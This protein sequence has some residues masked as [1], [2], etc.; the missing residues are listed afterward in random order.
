M[1]ATVISSYARS[2]KLEKCWNVKRVTAAANDT[3]FFWNIYNRILARGVFTKT[4]FSKYRQRHCNFTIHP[5]QESTC[6]LDAP[7]VFCLEE[8]GC[9]SVSSV[10]TIQA[11]RLPWWQMRQTCVL[12]TAHPNT[13]QR[14]NG[15][16]G[17]KLC[18]LPRGTVL[19]GLRF[20]LSARSCVSH[21]EFGEA[22][23]TTSLKAVVPK[24]A[25]RTSPGE[26]EVLPTNL[27]V[28]LLPREAPTTSTAS[29]EQ[30]GRRYLPSG[31]GPQTIEDQWSLLQ[32]VAEHSL[33]VFSLLQCVRHRQP[34]YSHP[35]CWRHI[36]F[37]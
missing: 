8:A 28:C 37:K 35:F 25:Q 26:S 2:I 17:G 30:I 33:S 1:M 5:K 36:P 12:T 27:Q 6:Y 7:F 4:Y 9:Y 14:G 10:T 31:F 20:C 23:P 24:R 16:G 29:V 11:F 21:S 32:S 13:P 18:S 15:A 34:R 19:N 3:F 22:K